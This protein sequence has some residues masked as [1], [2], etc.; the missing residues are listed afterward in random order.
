MESVE[1]AEVAYES[2]ETEELLDTHEVTLSEEEVRRGVGAFMRLDMGQPGCVLGVAG[3]YAFWKVFLEVGEA[4]DKVSIRRAVV[5]LPIDR[6]NAEVF[7]ESLGRLEGATEDIEGQ[8]R[9]ADDNVE[10]D[11]GRAD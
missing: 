8:D 7:S 1:E 11:D 6:G 2:V 3:P 5:L 9:G 10:D 4:T